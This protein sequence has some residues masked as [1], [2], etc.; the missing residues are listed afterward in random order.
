MSD[1]VRGSSLAVRIA[2]VCAGAA[3]VGALVSGLLAARLVTAAAREAGRD[4]LAAQTALVAGQLDRADGRPRATDRVL[5]ALGDQGIEAV[6]VDEGRATGAAVDVLRASDVTR[7]AG[8]RAVSTTR[9]AGAGTYLVEGRPTSAGQ[10]VL[11]VQ[12]AERASGDVSRRLAG[13]VAFAAVV[14]A[15]VA[16]AAGA[17]LAWWVSRPLRAAAGAVGRLR[18]GHR[19]VR[20]RVE[21]PQEAAVLAAAVNDL[22]DDLARSEARERE[23][24]LSVSHDLRTPLTAV[25]GA[26]E[27]L[28][29]GVVEDPAEVRR[30]GALVAEQARRLDRMVQDLLDLARLGAHDLPLDLLPVDLDAL[31]RM[32]ADGWRD[33]AAAVGARCEVE[34]GTGSLTVVTDASRVR[35]VLD[36]LCDNA[37]RHVDAGGLVVLAARSAPAG[38]VLEVRDDGPGL[39]PDDYPVAFERGVLAERH[40]SR[41]PGGAGVGLSLVRALV[42]RLGGRAEAGPAPEGGACLRVVLPPS[43]QV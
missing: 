41:R 23:F 34:V 22:A 1:A 5:Q 7:V 14:G 17:S 8:G 42:T 30:Y 40:R 20:V 24:L 29:D 9:R 11:L 26:A 16:V 33:R 43:A 36:S 13:R 19:D 3:V 35:Q 21:G 4:A 15:A 2:L 12:E 27:A 25:T 18:S 32:T 39:D 38:V 6:V 37:F 28:A 31:V 10:G